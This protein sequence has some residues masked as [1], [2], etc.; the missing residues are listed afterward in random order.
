MASKDNVDYSSA[1]A[2]TE[3]TGTA[4]IVTPVG[5]N[6]VTDTKLTIR[7]KTE[8]LQYSRLDT[9]SATV[10]TDRGQNVK[11]TYSCNGYFIGTLDLEAAGIKLDQSKLTL[12]AHVSTKDGRELAAADGDGTVSVKLGAKPEQTVDDEIGRA[13]V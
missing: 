9:E 5:G 12:T 4:R 13:H 11:L 2:A 10:T 8:G 1:P 7:V 3:Q 6:R